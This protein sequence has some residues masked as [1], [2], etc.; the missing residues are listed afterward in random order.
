MN[1][2]AT[3]RRRRIAVLGG[4]LGGL[5]RGGL[6]ANQEQQAVRLAGHRQGVGDGERGWAVQH[7]EVE[8]GA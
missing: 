2:H 4:G 1:V 5:G 3:S 8:V 7:D 6:P